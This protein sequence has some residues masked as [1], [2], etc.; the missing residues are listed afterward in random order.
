MSTISV[1]VIGWMSCAFAGLAIGIQD[2]P[3]AIAAAIVAAV[4]LWTA[5]LA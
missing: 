5:S 1:R 4:L 3:G 2:W